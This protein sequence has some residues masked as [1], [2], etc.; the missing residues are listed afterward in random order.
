MFF[1]L[2]KI[3]II[4]P[5]LKFHWYANGGL[6]VNKIDNPD[7]GLIN[8][9]RFLLDEIEAEKKYNDDYEKAKEKAKKKAEAD[10]YPWSQRLSNY[11]DTTTF[12]HEPRMSVIKEN[13]KTIRRLLLKL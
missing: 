5:G 1:K 6:K 4:K 9:I 10:G 2:P 3:E 7:Q 11:M 8:V 12:D 13:A